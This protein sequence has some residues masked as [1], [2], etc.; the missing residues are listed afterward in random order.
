MAHMNPTRKTKLEDLEVLRRVAQERERLTPA[1][2]ARRKLAE[3]R[4]FIRLLEAADSGRIELDRRRARFGACVQAPN[5]DD[6][7]YYGRLREWLDRSL[8]IV[9]A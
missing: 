4:D 1:E 7:E 3:L 9:S 6:C 2:R 5:E 8:E